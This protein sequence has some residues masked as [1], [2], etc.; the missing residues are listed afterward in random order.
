MPRLIR[1]FPGPHLS[2]AP[3]VAAAG[4][5]SATKPW[6]TCGA[7]PAHDAEPR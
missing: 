2:A 1:V 7:R 5:L 4:A 3:A 6:P